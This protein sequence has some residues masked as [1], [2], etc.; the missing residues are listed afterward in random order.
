MKRGGRCS[1]F[2]ERGEEREREAPG[3]R[4]NDGLQSH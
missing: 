1:T 4:R 2:I 3:R